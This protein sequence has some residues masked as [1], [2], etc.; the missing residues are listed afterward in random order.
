MN[1]Y[2]NFEKD[3]K[4]LMKINN[5]CSGVSEVQEEPVFENICVS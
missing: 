1:F 3:L 4:N 5:S 2:K